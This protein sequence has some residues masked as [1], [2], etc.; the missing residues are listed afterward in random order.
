MWYLGSLDGWLGL[1]LPDVSH[2]TEAKKWLWCCEWCWSER[3]PNLN[4]VI[5][6]MILKHGSF[7]NCTLWFQYPMR[8]LLLLF[9]RHLS[10]VLKRVSVQMRELWT[11]CTLQAKTLIPKIDTVKLVSGKKQLYSCSA[12]LQHLIIIFKKNRT[13]LDI[14]MYD[15]ILYM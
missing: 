4:F 3:S 10:S 2:I 13:R 1:F 5:N 15:I 6:Y 12:Q 11:W 7:Y 9:N 14:L 8:S